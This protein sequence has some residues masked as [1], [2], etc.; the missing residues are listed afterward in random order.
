MQILKEGKL[1]Y[2]LIFLAYF[3]AFINYI[4][5]LKVIASSAELTSFNIFLSSIKSMIKNNA[6][7][8][9]SLIFFI[10]ISVVICIII[11]LLL[12]IIIKKAKSFGIDNQ[13]LLKLK[14]Y[15]SK[16]FYIKEKKPFLGLVFALF[17]AGGSIYLKHFIFGI[18]SILTYP[19][20]IIWEIIIGYFGSLKVNYFVTSQFVNE[21]YVAEEKKLDHLLLEVND[22]GKSYIVAKKE[23]DQKYANILTK[24]SVE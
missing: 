12:L 13:Q 21:N 8:Y 23:L 17:P 2:F 9:F 15:Q 20:S 5:I 22:N 14:L 4:F 18:I 16:G 24:P 3:L 11:F 10:N 1:K 19:L 7:D 6:N